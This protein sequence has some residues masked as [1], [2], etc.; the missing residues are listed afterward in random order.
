MEAFWVRSDQFYVPILLQSDREGI[1]GALSAL[2][3]V[4]LRFLVEDAKLGQL[5]YTSVLVVFALRLQD[6]VLLIDQVLFVALASL[7]SCSLHPILFPTL[8]LF[9][10]YIKGRLGYNRLQYLINVDNELYLVA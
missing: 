8:C 6:L 3:S 2:R 9:L 10:Y 4:D 7:T 5:C 1:K